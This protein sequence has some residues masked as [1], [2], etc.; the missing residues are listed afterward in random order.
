MPVEGW[1]LVWNIMGYK[2]SGVLL[3]C[4]SR[5]AASWKISTLLCIKMEKVE[6]TR[7]AER[8][9]QFEGIKAPG[10]FCR[11]KIM[12]TASCGRLF[13]RLV[14]KAESRQNLQSTSRQQIRQPQSAPGERPDR[15]KICWGYVSIT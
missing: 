2:V 15:D 12:T 11:R 9:G 1:R 5:S 6:Q 7:A 13:D 4:A 10:T 3:F 14:T 8:H